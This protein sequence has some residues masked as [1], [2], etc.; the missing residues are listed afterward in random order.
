MLNEIKGR[1]A[2]LSNPEDGRFLQKYFKTAPGQ[3]GEGD[4]FRGIRV[5]VLR[6][7]SR[8]YRDIPLQLAELL[9]RSEH[10]EDRLLAL[11]ILV[12]KYARADEAGRGGIY[13][14]YL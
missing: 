1:L 3:Y 9:L 4:I 7:L 14:L 8:E 2:G 12:L 10:H 11:L 6:R 13:Q 5:P